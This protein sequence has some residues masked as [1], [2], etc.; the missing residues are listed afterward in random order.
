MFEAVSPAYR[1]QLAELHAQRP[2][3]GARGHRWAGEVPKWADTFGAVTFLDYGCGKATL[4]NAVF[5]AGKTQ[6]GSWQDYDPALDWSGPPRPADLVMCLDVLE[7]VEPDR[8]DDVLDDL[9]GL[10]LKACVMFVDTSPAHKN[11]PDGRNAHILQRPL[12]WWLDKIQDR[13]AIHTLLN[14]RPEFLCIGIP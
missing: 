13:F 4:G 6:I 1:D 7:H 9:R 2:D 3:F 12:R 14:E 10:T 11:L 8:I 5:T